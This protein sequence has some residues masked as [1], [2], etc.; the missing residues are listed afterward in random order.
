M[1]GEVGFDQPFSQ[2][3]AFHGHARQLAVEARPLLG[4]LFGGLGRRCVVSSLRLEKRVV[5]VLE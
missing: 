2:L 5:R 4:E 1:Q 3:V